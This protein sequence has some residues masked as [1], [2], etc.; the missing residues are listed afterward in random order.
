ML[1]E[2][3]RGG[4]ADMLERRDVLKGG[5]AAC[6]LSG[7]GP[8]AAAMP[9]FNAINPLLLA[10]ART[11]LERK[12][13]FLR[14]TDTF[15]IADF[16]RP[17]GEARFHLVDVMSGQ[18][19]SYHVAHGRGSDPMHSGF[20][21]RFSDEPGSNASSA[22]A[23]VTGDYYYG[24]YGRSLKLRGLDYSNRR[25]E[26]RNIVMHAAPYAE[27]S[28]LDRYGKL[29]RSE[30]CFAFSRANH[31]TML[32]RLGPGRLLYCDKV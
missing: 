25:A 11:A 4:F 30:G 10:R 21:H 1:A 31:Q 23:Y 16:S 2:A 26:A 7:A 5:V 13:P 6:L 17:S 15:A 27:R 9:A 29:G 3:S 19:T 32:Q 28:I 20:V 18:V 8:L 22:G 12:R 14:H 24:K